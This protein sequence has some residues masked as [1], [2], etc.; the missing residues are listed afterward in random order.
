V[1]S[2]KSQ[3]IDYTGVLKGEETEKLSADR[4][5][6][7][8]LENDPNPVFTLNTKGEFVYA[9][10]SGK[11]LMEVHGNF[12]EGSS[13]NESIKNKVAESL[14]SQKTVETSFR[15]GDV[16][17]GLIFR[18]RADKQHV[19]VF[20]TDI[21]E[22]ANHRK[23]FEII[24]AFSTSLLQ[25]RTENDVAWTIVREA[26]SRLAYLD[27]VVYLYDRRSG[28]LIQRAALGA[29]S[30]DPDQKEIQNPIRLKIGEGIVGSAALEQRT[31]IINDLSSDQRYVV[32]DAKRSSEIAVPIIAENELIGVIDS[33]HPEKGF[34]SATDA[35]IL[36]SI[37]SISATG[38]QRARAGEEIKHAEDRYRNLVENAFGGIYILRDEHFEY[39]N[40]RFAE[41]TGYTAEELTSSEFDSSVLIHRADEPAIDAMQ[42][43][44]LG[45]YSPKSY[46]LEILT[47]QG[48]I[49]NLAINTSIVS[50]ELGYYALGVTLDITE[51]VKSKKELEHV[52][53]SLEKRT[54]ELDEFAHLASHNLR[55]PVTNLMGLLKHYNHYDP[56]DPS[57]S[58][59]VERFEQSVKQLNLTLEEM[60][61]VLQVRAESEFEYGSVCLNKVLEDA[62]SQISQKVK[63]SRLKLDTDFEVAEFKYVRRHIENV[64][65][66]LITNAI[67]YG[68]PKRDPELR[69]S[70]KQKGGKILLTFMDKGLGIDL[71]KHGK[72]IFGMYKRFHSNPDSR[73]LGLYLIKKQLES[74]G[75]EIS[76][77]SEPGLGTTFF[78]TLNSK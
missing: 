74:L 65:L 4:D 13:D 64:F 36:E 58:A 29:K 51:T 35:K 61:K 15:K 40:D 34:Y 57:N 3:F 47:K 70:S 42:S 48:E 31:I 19:D 72:D 78:V 53:R 43:R 50:D 16:H 66:N 68:K 10:P 30:P 26:I 12:F 38:I 60:H 56:T 22:E 59:I 44:L 7:S 46:Q 17:I 41:I 33:E 69:I 52:I 62:I 9:N 20:G 45:D 71:E 67:K 37:A 28:E 8:Y 76:V 39:V 27:C 14:K 6:F 1:R 25:T 2:I 54:K 63:S 77:E 49:R 5:E 11:S 75:S 55:S 23:F 73:G 18:P 21:S 32:D 24:S